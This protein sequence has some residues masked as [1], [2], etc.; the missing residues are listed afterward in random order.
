[1]QILNSTLILNL[2][3]YHVQLNIRV[4]LSQN[5]HVCLYSIYEFCQTNTF[6][7]TYISDNSTFLSWILERLSN[8]P[9]IDF[10]G[11]K[12]PY[13]IKLSLIFLFLNKMTPTS[14][15]ASQINCIVAFNKHLQHWSDE[16]IK[17]LNWWYPSRDEIMNF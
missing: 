11:M 9:N 17:Q 6:L 1:M 13:R 16:N 3:F 2:T 5:N 15:V 7:R 14:F 8:A 10:V 4:F 12:N